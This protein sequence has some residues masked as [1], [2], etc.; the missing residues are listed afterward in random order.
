ML[1]PPSEAIYGKFIVALGTL[2]CPLSGTIQNSAIS[3]LVITFGLQRDLVTQGR[4]LGFSLVFRAEQ[5]T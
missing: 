2:L 1:C 5:L 4:G 3:P